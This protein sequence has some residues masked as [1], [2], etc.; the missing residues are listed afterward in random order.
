MIRRRLLLIVELRPC[1]VPV[2]AQSDQQAS[3][4]TKVQLCFES[5]VSAKFTYTEVL[6]EM[7]WN[8]DWL[9]STCKA[10]IR[11]KG[12]K[13]FRNWCWRKDFFNVFFR[14]VDNRRALLLCK[15]PS[16]SV[17]ER[18]WHT[19]TWTRL[20]ISSQVQFGLCK[21]SLGQEPKNCMEKIGFQY[22]S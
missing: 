14:A 7:L 6:E 16:P 20:K 11:F 8:P 17:T 12:R 2:S 19:E 5:V 15:C 4:F 1:S 22:S 10:L 18:A 13:G 3:F 9:K 21:W